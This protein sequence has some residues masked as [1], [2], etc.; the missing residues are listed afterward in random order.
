MVALVTVSPSRSVC[1]TIPY[2]AASLWSLSEQGFS[3]DVDDL[4]INDLVD[5]V[6]KAKFGVRQIDDVV[7]SF[8]RKKLSSIEKQNN[9]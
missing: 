1:S 7:R 2:T 3:I 9:I 5:E 8:L 6:Q 4:T